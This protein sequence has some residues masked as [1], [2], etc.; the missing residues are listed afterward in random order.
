MLIFG[1]DYESIENTK[2]FL[3]SSFDMKDLGIAD[4][5]LGIRIVRNENRL[6]LNQSHYIEKVLKR[7]NQFDCKPVYTPFD[8][9]MKLYPNTGR[10][11]NQLEYARVISCL[12]YAMTCTRPD[13]AYVVGK[14][15]KYTSNPSHIHWNAVHRI[16]RY[17]RRTMDYDILYSRYPT[18]LEGYTDVSWIT[19]ND[20]HK[21]T[22]GWIFTL[23]GGAI[24]C[25]SKKQ[26][27]ITDSTM[28]V[29][30]VAL[31]SYSKKQN[32]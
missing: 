12:M 6:V 26:T 14:M 10:A 8:A 16:L 23:G 1:T 5:I 3:S 4:V 25:G 28:T 27:L 7:F 31:A 11:V 17:L 9:S 15:S 2:N 30:F 18:I 13:I 21:S 24:S 20:D 32:D 19:D 22:N 29:E